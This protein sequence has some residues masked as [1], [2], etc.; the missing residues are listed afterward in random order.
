MLHFNQFHP[1]YPVEF[2]LSVFTANEGL[3]YGVN[4]KSDSLFDLISIRHKNVVI[5]LLTSF[6]H[7][8]RWSHPLS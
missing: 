5:Q 8:A 3:I 4:L 6:T 7:S 2:H 1:R